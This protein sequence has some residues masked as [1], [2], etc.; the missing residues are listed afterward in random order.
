MCQASDVA[1]GIFDLLCGVRDLF[2]FFSAMACE[3]LVAAC[4]IQFPEQGSS[5]GPLPWEC[6]VLATEP[7]GKPQEVE[8]IIYRNS[9]ET[10]ALP[11]FPEI[12]LFH[13]DQHNHCWGPIHESRR[14]LAV[15]GPRL[16][17]RWRPLGVLRVQSSI[18]FLFINNYKIKIMLNY[19]TKVN[20]YTPNSKPFIFLIILS[21]KF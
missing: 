9:R 8:Y 12:Q 17:T 11:S 6:G 10:W 15:R 20:T 18:K 19:K 14:E 4:G 3:V 13:T 7:P 5:P 2:F 1:L 16:W 21:V